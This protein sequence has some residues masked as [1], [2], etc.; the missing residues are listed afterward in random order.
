MRRKKD[1]KKGNKYSREELFIGVPLQS[2]SELIPSIDIG[3]GTRVMECERQSLDILL[4]PGYVT[5]GA[6]NCL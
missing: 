3:P 1:R 5:P 6:F 2:R 4:L